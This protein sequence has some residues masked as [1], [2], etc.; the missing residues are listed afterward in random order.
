MPS[1]ISE[2][3]SRKTAKDKLHFLNMAQASLSEMDAQLEI[4]DRLRFIDSKAIEST[5]GLL[6]EVEMILIGLMKSIRNQ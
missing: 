1:N 6:T 2:G 3:L 5:Y 4:S